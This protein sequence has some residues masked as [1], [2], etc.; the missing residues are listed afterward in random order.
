M[1]NVDRKFKWTH[2]CLGCLEPPPVLLLVLDHLAELPVVEL[3][4]AAGVELVK[5][6][7]HLE[8]QSAVMRSILPDQCHTCS[9]ESFVQ[10]VINS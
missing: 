6:H 1:W 3:V 9:F 10:I 2:V 7:P 5:R 4:V 8:T